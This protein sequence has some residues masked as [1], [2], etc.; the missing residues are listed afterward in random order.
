M[1]RTLFQWGRDCSRVIFHRMHTNSSSKWIQPAGFVCLKLIVLRMWHLVTIFACWWIAGVHFKQD[2]RQL[3][4]M[5]EVIIRQPFYMQSSPTHT[6]TAGWIG[7]CQLHSENSK[8]KELDGLSQITPSAHKPTA[9]FN[10]SFTLFMTIWECVS[11]AHLLLKSRRRE[12]DG[13]WEESATLILPLIATNF[14]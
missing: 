5:W 6:H 2:I 11:T 7:S 4:T 13:C 1:E 8:P 3:L 10:Y 9:Y 12:Q 14:K